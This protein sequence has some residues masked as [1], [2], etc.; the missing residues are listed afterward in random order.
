MNKI[1]IDP[2]SKRNQN[3]L[4]NIYCFIYTDFLEKGYYISKSIRSKYNSTKYF[5]QILNTL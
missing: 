1:N 2:Q 4:G 3:Y 5:I